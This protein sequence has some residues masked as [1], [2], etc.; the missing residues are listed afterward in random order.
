MRARKGEAVMVKRFAYKQEIPN[1]LIQHDPKVKDYVI[2]NMVNELAKAI[3]DVLSD[4][5]LYAMQMSKPEIDELGALNQ[6]CTAY[7]S[8]V[9]YNELLSCKDCRSYRYG[10]CEK[11]ERSNVRPYDYC[12]WAVRKEY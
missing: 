8:T 2:E 9:H 10:L 3:A 12:S 5:K 6:N 7:R 1:E 11:H 4:G